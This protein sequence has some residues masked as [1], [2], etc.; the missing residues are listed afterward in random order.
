MESGYYND[1]RNFY[2]VFGG[3]IGI[4]TGDCSFGNEKYEILFFQ[5][6]EK[7]Y[8]VGEDIFS[9]ENV[10]DEDKL[11]LCFNDVKQVDVI[12]N[13]LLKVKEQL[14]HKEDYDSKENK[15]S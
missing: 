5:E 1:K 13:N 14:Q 4:G 3:K 2:I 7:Q 15:K 12:I 11:V 10:K 8:E 9:K 6:V